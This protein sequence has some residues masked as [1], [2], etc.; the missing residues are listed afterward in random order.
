MTQETS[1]SG[2][3]LALDTSTPR[4]ALALGRVGAPEETVLLD[5]DEA[6][7][8]Q[9]SSQLT[10]R[11]EALAERAGI[12]LRELSAIACGR[13]PGTFTG[14]RVAVATAKGLALARGCPVY[15]VSTL[16]ALASSAPPEVEGLTLALLDARRGEVYSAAF[17]RAPLGRPRTE[18][19]SRA[20]SWRSQERCG[21]LRDVLEVYLDSGDPLPWIVGPGA[22]AHHEQI[23]ERA[24]GH[25]R[26]DVV[27]TPAGLWRAAVDARRNDAPVAL[28]SFD[29]EYLRVSY[30]EMGINT[31]KRPVTRSPYV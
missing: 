20:L 22:R 10:P 12:A 24:R 4:S 2:W 28:E 15:A 6:R 27:L 17:H 11:I 19:L 5:V 1:T 7:A 8:N 26:D 23:P 3:L 30:A 18:S 14:S 16:A 9:A 13:G 25:V 31:P 21:P 29:A